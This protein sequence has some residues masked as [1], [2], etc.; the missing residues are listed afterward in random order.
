MREVLTFEAVCFETEVNTSVNLQRRR[1]RTSR[2]FL[3]VVFCFSKSWEAE[4]LRTVM[5]VRLVE[6]RM[7]IVGYISIS[8]AFVACF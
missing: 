2:L 6:G 3:V 5:L 4:K 7:V 8:D 1:E